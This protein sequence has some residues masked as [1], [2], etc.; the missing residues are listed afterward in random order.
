MKTKTKFVKQ[1]GNTALVLLTTCIAFASI[2]AAH[3]KTKAHAIKAPTSRCDVSLVYADPRQ[4]S[5]ASPGIE[6]PTLAPEVTP[7]EAPKTKADKK[8][9]GAAESV[10]KKG[11]ILEAVYTFYGPVT[12]ES[13]AIFAASSETISAACRT[14]D[15]DNLPSIRIN[16]NTPGGSVYDGFAFVDEVGRLRKLGHR[17]TIAAYG[18]AASA[19]SW[20]MQS[21]DNRIIGAHAKM[22]IHQVSSEVEGKVYELKMGTGLADSLWADCIA[23]LIQNPKCKLTEKTIRE[24]CDRGDD[25]WLTAKEVLNYGLAD[26]IEKV[27]ALGTVK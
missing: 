21:A 27:P 14:L 2:P 6:A 5:N 20:M 12:P 16:L 26:E 19:G 4:S 25:W 3:G 17:V 7:S 11:K 13:V 15:K 10:D 1:I 9:D 23:T 18:M 8:D 24:H 22:L